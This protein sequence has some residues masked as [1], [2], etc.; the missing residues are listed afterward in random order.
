MNIA[1]LAG[2]ISTERD[3]SLTSGRNVVN[4]LRRKGQ[5]AVLIDLFLGY[6]GADY[7]DIFTKNS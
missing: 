5:N 1:V 7:A 4:A 6:P 2:G 3:V